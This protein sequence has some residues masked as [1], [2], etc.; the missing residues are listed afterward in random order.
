MQ[1][2]DFDTIVIGGG[3]AGILASI[4]SAQRGK[5]TLL[6]ERNKTLGKKLLITGKGRCNLTN[7]TDIR[8]LVDN[9]PGNGNFLY[10]SFHT[11]SNKDL[12]NLLNSNGLETKTERGGRVFPASDS[13]KDVLDTLVRICRNSG[14]VIKTGLRISKLTVSDGKITGAVSDSGMEIRCKSVILATGGLSYPSTGSTGDGYRMAKELGHSIIQPRASLVPLNTEEKYVSMMQGLTLKNVSVVFRNNSGKIIY[15]DFGELLF[16]HYGVSGPVILSGSR[17]LADYG[18]A[19]A[20]VSIDMK[21]ALTHEQLDGR[22][23]RDFMKF[24]RKN[25]KNSLD[26]LLP[27]KAIPVIVKLSGIPGDKPVNQVTK[28]ERQSLVSILKDFRL[29]V[30][31]PRPIEEAVVTAGGIAVHEVEPATM[32]SKIIKGLYF[33]GEILDVDGYTG[34]FNL[35]I[36]FSTGYT[37]GNSC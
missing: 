35:T 12:I 1:E 7:D 34:G 10:S 9:I 19:G 32:Q 30:T 27:K 36:A 14:V 3:P 24:S 28:A 2:L 25:F 11:F 20:S 22:I 4:R 31:G 17:H 6:A 15:S 13:S 5:R 26:E 23:V 18:Y 21:P 29:H 16:T 33:A 8:G 37:A